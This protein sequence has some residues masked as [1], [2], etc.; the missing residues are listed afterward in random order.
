MIALY[1]TAK[2]AEGP[3]RTRCQTK[4]RNRDG[5]AE[6]YQPHRRPGRAGEEDHERS[7]QGDR[8]PGE[9]DRPACAR[10]C[11]RRP[12]TAGRRAGPCED[13]EREH[14]REGA[15]P[16]LQAHI[17]HAGPSA[18]RRGWHADLFAEDGRILAEEGPGVHEPAAGGRDKPR[19]SEGA[20]RASRVH[21]GEAG[22]DRRDHLPSSPAVPRARHAEPDR[23][24]GHLSSSRGAGRPLHV[25]VPRRDAQPQRRAPHHGAL[26]AAGQPAR[27]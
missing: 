26:R 16:R 4:E 18:G 2:A 23:A 17:V 9:A 11:D 7:G 24:G 5:S 8:G 22:D 21:A 1:F 10:A 20:E 19:A 12:H 3:R 27:G 14:A 15:G 25:Q 6:R 13:L